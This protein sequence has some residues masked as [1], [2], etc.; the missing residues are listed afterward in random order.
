MMQIK[1]NFNNFAQR[2]CHSLAACQRHAPSS[3]AAVI[4]LSNNDAISLRSLR[5][6]RGVGWKPRFTN[7]SRWRRLS[8]RAVQS[9]T[10]RWLPWRSPA[11]VASCWLRSARCAG[12]WP[13]CRSETRCQQRMLQNTILL[14]ALGITGYIWHQWPAFVLRYV[15]NCVIRMHSTTLKSCQSDNIYNQV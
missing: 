14:T 5:C 2:V 3:L 11:S 8:Q 9:R 6:V 10:L 1:F 7:R 15:I 13:N 12:C 4:G